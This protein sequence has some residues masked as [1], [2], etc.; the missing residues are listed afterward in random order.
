M[1]SKVRNLFLALFCLLVFAAL[2]FVF[3]TN[4]VVQRPFAVILFV[5]SNLTPNHL[6]VARAY[7]SNSGK[8]LYLDRLPIRG[9]LR[10]ASKDSLIPDSAAAASALATGRKIPN[11]VASCS[12][13]G[14]KLTTL[15]DAA[16]ARGRATGIISN[17]QIF[18]PVLAAF[19]APVPD[20]ADREAIGRQMLE[21]VKLDILLG[22]GRQ[23]WV[24]SLQGGARKDN[25]DLLLQVRKV[26]YD[27]VRTRKE[28]L[29]TPTWRSPRVVGVFA[30]GDM[31]YAEDFEA[32]ATQP[33]LSDMVAQAIQLLQFNGKG[34]FLVVDA[35]LVEKAAA[36][37]EAEVMVRELLMLDQAVAAAVKYA[38]EDALVVVA[39]TNAIGGFNLSGDAQSQDQ[40]IGLFVPLSSG[41]PS[42]TWAT[43]KN[44]SPATAESSLQNTRR[45]G[46]LQQAIAVDTPTALPVASDVFF[47]AKDTDREKWGT[48]SDNTQIY[49]ILSEQF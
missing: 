30:E 29:V 26:G 22:G 13:T 47:F 21:N 10:N 9:T 33:S 4:W 25:K 15:L 45:R 14:E 23:N 3:Y 42:I 24:S 17:G 31:A 1:T 8:L 35:G 49:K 43:G 37:N 39:G 20:V 28:L 41:K 2:G 36:E 34:Y 32:A 12:A 19:A 18:N 11:G 46:V 27:I 6:A 38:G 7:Q 48:V 16:A 40:G 44:N 5:S